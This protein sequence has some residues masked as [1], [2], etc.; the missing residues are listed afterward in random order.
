MVYDFS[1]VSGCQVF[2][3]SWLLVYN[4]LFNTTSV[5]T[6]H[7]DELSLLIPDIYNLHEV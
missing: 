4:K 3:S 7:L 2:N 1:Q 5:L 6:S